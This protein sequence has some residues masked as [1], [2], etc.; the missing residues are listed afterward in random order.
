MEVKTFLPS[1]ATN[2][3]VTWYVVDGTG[4]A[5]IDYRGTLT[6]LTNGTITVTG[7]GGATAINS[8]GGSLLMQDSVAPS[9]PSLIENIH[10]FYAITLV[11]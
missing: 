8:K 2:T 11:S 7:Y 3:D 9:S 1:N 4:N 10:S 6:A 5:K